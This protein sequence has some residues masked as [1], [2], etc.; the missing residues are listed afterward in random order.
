MGFR[1]EGWFMS[2]RWSVQ[3]EVVDRVGQELQRHLEE[4]SKRVI[5]YFSPAGPWAGGQFDF[6]GQDAHG[7]DE[8]G[9][10]DLLAVNLLGIR[11][12]PLM[13]REFLRG[14][15][16]QHVVADAL[17]QIPATARLWDDGEEV[18]DVVDGLWASIRRRAV[19][20]AV[21][22][23]HD[24]RVTAMGDAKISKLLARK[25]PE[26]VPISDKVVRANLP[27]P[28]GTDRWSVYRSVLRHESIGPDL[29]HR[30]DELR[31]EIRTTIGME[32]SV[33]RVLDAAVWLP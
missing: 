17:V 16:L 13:V 29:I 9:C 28:H 6:W 31:R 26:L 14:P 4:N 18:L 25:R 27:M 2:E 7:V 3:G 5:R 15:A 12:P 20:V 30:A 19:E 22:H 11:I 10:H 24:P 1:K 33:L 23:K 8:I 21:E 32:P